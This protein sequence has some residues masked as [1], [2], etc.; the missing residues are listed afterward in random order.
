[1]LKCD[2]RS[3][4]PAILIR[5]PGC[6]LRCLKDPGKESCMLSKKLRFISSAALILLGLIVFMVVFA[7]HPQIQ[8]AAAQSAPAAQNPP[9]NGSGPA[10]PAPELP[11]GTITY[12]A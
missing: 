3:S 8:A 6:V 2:K 4:T 7:R 9:T 10:A 5:V 11:P 1:M 12:T